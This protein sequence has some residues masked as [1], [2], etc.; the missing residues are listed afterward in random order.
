MRA[1]RKRG[2]RSPA[3]Q[4]A[5]RNSRHHG[6]MAMHDRSM[7]LSTDVRAFTRACVCTRFDS[8]NAAPL[9]H[10]KHRRCTKRSRDLGYPV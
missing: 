3:A 10:V 4:G 6:A 7:F 5:S 1:P 9:T 2:R 8:Q